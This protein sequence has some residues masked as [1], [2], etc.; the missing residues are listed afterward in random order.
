V[1]KTLCLDF[2]GVLHLYVSGWQGADVIPDPPVEGAME[3]LAETVE[4][5]QVVVY[6]SRSHQPNGIIA[7][8]T[9]L[10]LQLH[11]ALGTEHAEHVYNLIGWPLEKPSAYLAIDDRVYSFRGV[12]PDVGELQAFK[13]WNHHLKKMPQKSL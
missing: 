2:D 11:R 3:F 5:F 1:K 8:Q 7:M 10:Q 13:P 12:W 4:H 6:S 9:W